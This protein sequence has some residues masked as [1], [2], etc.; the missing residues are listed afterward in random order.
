MVKAWQEYPEPPD[1]P[2]EEQIRGIVFQSLDLKNL[3][4]EKY[5]KVYSRVPFEFA[6]YRDAKTGELGIWFI[7]P[8][9]NEYACLIRKLDK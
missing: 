1:V 7:D 5:P 4:A 2:V 8:E 9:G 6:Q 3:F